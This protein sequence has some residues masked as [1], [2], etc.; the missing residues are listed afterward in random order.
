MTTRSAPGEPPL[1][2]ARAGQH[3]GRR[4]GV[5]KSGR[6]TR[7]L[8]DRVFVVGRGACGKVDVLVVVVLVGV[9][10]GALRGAVV[11]V[12]QGLVRGVAEVVVGEGVAVAV[13]AVRNVVDGLRDGQGDDG[14]K[15]EE[16]LH[17][18]CFLEVWECGF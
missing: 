11:E 4:T 10:V 12:I 7:T 16:E 6:R 5:G 8:E 13:V 2:A 18:C 17:V 1:Y 9:V 14:G 3:A 15:G